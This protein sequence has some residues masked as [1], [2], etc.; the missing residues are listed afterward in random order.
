MKATARPDNRPHRR[1]L[2]SYL[3]AILFIATAT[4]GCAGSDHV[5][6]SPLRWDLTFYDE[7]SGAAGELPDPSRWTF[8]TGGFGWGNNESFSVEF[9]MKGVAG[10]TCATAGVSGNA[11]P[12]TRHG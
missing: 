2:L 8:D 9:W 6:E 5:V 4:H 1:V 12:L 11:R 10:T 7:F 3:V